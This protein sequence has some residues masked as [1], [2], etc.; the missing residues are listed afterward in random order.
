MQVTRR[1][2]A[3]LTVS[4]VAASCGGMA[5]AGIGADEVTYDPALDID[6]D[7]MTRTESGLYLQDLE[8]GTGETVQAGDE[9]TAHFLGWF[10][11]GTLFQTTV[12]GDPM[13]ARVGP[14]LLPGWI[15]GI[16]GMRVGG[17]RR[18][19]VPP[20]LAFGTRGDPPEIP[21]N[22]VLVFEIQLLSIP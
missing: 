16:P 14:E 17:I 20:G 4:F 6:L 5:Q 15:E 18:L 10:P 22:A 9:F 3:L 12:G 21:G 11:D 8:E 7:R 2:F 13:T 1:L 19:V